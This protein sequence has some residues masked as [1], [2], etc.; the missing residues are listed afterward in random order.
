M[1]FEALQTRT[2]QK[3]TVFYC[4]IIV[5]NFYTV[6]GSVSTTYILTFVFVNAVLNL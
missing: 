5:T 6:C 4:L 1:H 3:E 2:L